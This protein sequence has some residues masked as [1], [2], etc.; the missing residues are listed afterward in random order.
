VIGNPYAARLS[1]N[2]VREIKEMLAQDVS[3]TV[4]SNKYNISRQIITDI[5]SGRIWGYV[6]ASD[7]AEEILRRKRI[8]RKIKNAELAARRILQARHPEE[9]EAIKSE[10]LKED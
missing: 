10:L 7:E 3:N 8:E 5:K 6:K 1:Q 9:F 2:Q 4:L